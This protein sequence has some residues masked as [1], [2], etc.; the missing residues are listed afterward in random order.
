MTPDAS[1]RASRA[2]GPCRS[3][4]ARRRASGGCRSGAAKDHRRRCRR[5]AMARFAAAAT[6]CVGVPSPPPRAP[7]RRT[8]RRCTPSTSTS[9]S[10]RS[11]VRLPGCA[12]GSRRIIGRP[13]LDRVFLP[14]RDH[15]RR[16]HQVDDPRGVVASELLQRERGWPGATIGQ[17]S[18][19]Q[20]LE[21]VDRRGVAGAA[22][23]LGAGAADVGILVLQPLLERAAR[24]PARRS[25]PARR[26]RTRRPRLSCST[27]AARS[28][29][30]IARCSRIAP[31]ARI[32]A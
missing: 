3:D 12:A 5:R 8:R 20:A 4:R 16:A 17:S 25:A 23:A 7:A 9:A 21:R 6:D 1:P 24:W 2:R 27:R 22:E 30:P 26:A 31:S 14:L 11:G 32:A 19:R 15:L 29:A 10:R 28:S 13:E 18:R